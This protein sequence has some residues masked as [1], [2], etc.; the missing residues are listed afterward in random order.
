MS[1]HRR[2]PQPPG[3]SEQHRSQEAEFLSPQLLRE[4]RV[5]KEQHPAPTPTRERRRVTWL[6]TRG[7]QDRL[8]SQAGLGRALASRWVRRPTQG[9]SRS[10]L[11]APPL[12]AR[13]QAKRGTL[14]G[15]LPSHQQQR[16]LTPVHR[17]QHRPCFD[18][19]ARADPPAAPPTLLESTS[20]RMSLALGRHPQEMQLRA[21]CARQQSVRTLSALLQDRAAG[22]SLQPP[23]PSSQ[24]VPLEVAT[25]AKKR[26][27]AR[28][29][30]QASC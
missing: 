12:P 13:T 9:H 26:Q 5:E 15:D 30:Q 23:T 6:R 20:W 8:G 21:R 18:K 28:P 19:L 3:T 25:A 22:N 10:P 14:F 4:A 1:L 27:L 16:W 17:H 29:Q 24:I 11:Q 7:T 2:T